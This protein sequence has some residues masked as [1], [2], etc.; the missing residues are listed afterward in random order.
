METRAGGAEGL[1]Y[2]QRP[3]R[4]PTVPLSWKLAAAALLA[5]GLL[6]AQD[7][8]EW[9]LFSPPKGRFSIRLPGTP[10]ERVDPATGAH[11]FELRSGDQR[12]MVSWVDLSKAARRQ[13]PEQTLEET[14]DRFLKLL[15]DARLISSAPTSFSGSPGIT[16]ILETNPENRGALRMKGAAAISKGRVFTLGRMSG[17]YG[18]DEGAADRWMGTFKIS[19]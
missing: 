19:K 1:T 9:V 6:A 14:R 13:K 7:F 11:S 18:F 12:T 5:A 15:P 4:R 3:M 10:A 16:W 8:D 17:R 2:N